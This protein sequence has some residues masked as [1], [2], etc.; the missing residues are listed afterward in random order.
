MIHL[1]TERLLLRDWQDGDL[2][3]FAALNAD[4]RVMEFFPARLTRGQSDRFAAR[5]R[6]N[7]ARRDY[8]L[9]A[10]EPKDSGGFIGFVGFAHPA[11]KAHF[12]PCIEIGWRLAF[13]AW[14]RGYAS[15]AARAC[16]AHG[17]STFD[18]NEVVSFTAR[19]NARSIAV[20]ERIGM[21]RDRAGDFDHPALTDGHPLRRHA[22]YRIGRQ[23][24][25]GRSDQN[26]A[27]AFETACLPASPAPSRRW[28]A[29]RR[30]RPGCR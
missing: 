12:T 29:R 20:M 14:G 4:P 28:S 27:Q 6:A 19:Q 23:T 17:F 13:D 9:Y 30:P 25:R 21:S 7:L 10:V 1:E 18:F 8:G 2:A 26:G 22:L 11:L 5:I 16:L 3:P 24:E 15:E